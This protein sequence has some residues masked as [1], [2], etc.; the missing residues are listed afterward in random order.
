MKSKIHPSLIFRTPKFSYQ[1][2]LVSCWDELKKA[3]SISSAAFYETIKDV[4]AGELTNL[5][6]KIYFTIWKYFNRAKHRSTPYG[7]FA[8]FSFL[9]DGF[10]DE[11]DGITIHEEQL[12]HQFIDWPYRNEIHLNFEQLFADD[13]ILFSNTSYYLTHNSIRY[14]ACSDGIFELAEIDQHNF[15]MAIMA[16]CTVPIS[17]VN[18]VLKLDLDETTKAELYELLQDMHSLQLIFTDRDPNIIGEDY[19]KRLGLKAD[20][21]PKYLIAER[22]IISGG[23]DEKLL[24]PLPGLVEALSAI[25]NS[26]ERGALKSFIT[27]FKRKFDQQEVQLSIALDPE[28]GVGYDELE[29]A[30]EEDFVAQFTSAKKNDDGRKDLKSVLKTKLS[31]NVFQ[32]SDPIFLNNL[33]F[34]NNDKA[35]LLPNSFSLLMS[36]VDDLICIDQIGG[37]TANALTGRFTIADQAVEDYCKSISAIEQSAN[38]EV[39]FFDVAYLVETNVDNINRRKLVYDYQLS[40]LNFDTSSAPL[41]LR[42]IYISIRNDEVIL[43]SRQLNKR[44]IPRLA[45]AYN[46]TRSDLSVFR[47]LCDLQHHKIQTVLSFSLDSILPD[48]DFYPRFQHHNVVLSNAKWRVKKESFY[49]D[50]I[51][52]SIAACREYLHNI[53]LSRYFKTGSS[54]QTLCFDLLSDEDLN[55]FLQYMQKQTTLYLEEVMFPGNSIVRDEDGKPYSAQF[56]LSLYHENCIYKGLPGDNRLSESVQQVFL[57]GK[58]WL[59][60]EIYCHQQRSDE[61]LTVVIDA[62]LNDF[63]A[64]IKSWFFVR[65]NE[66]GNHLR[67]RI[68]LNNNE[69]GQVLLTSFSDYL[70]DYIES[71]LVSDLQVK[72]YKREL[73]RYGANLIA[74][75]EDHFALDSKVVLSFLQAQTDAFNKYKWCSKL[76]DSF[77]VAGIFGFE[78][79]IRMI[80]LVSDSFNEEHQIDAAGF[81][82]L[83]QHYQQYKNTPDFEFTSQDEIM[84]FQ[85]SFIELLK[86]TDGNKRVKLFTDLVHMHVNRLFNK[87]QRANEMVMYYFLLKDLQRK[88]AMN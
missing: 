5:P 55:A 86:L 23:L 56:I 66:N 45:S 18:L 12:V 3:I 37:V 1:A 44:L 11:S 48:L 27:R 77:R 64:K 46:Y 60:F 19:F 10:Q 13:A 76:I 17:I 43:R 57:P 50:K 38:P 54:D 33:S 29:Q 22:K 88:K 26:D 9:A 73:E 68:L 34:E 16:A 8:S 79:L 71:G 59:Y 21:L 32:N 30:G 7:T 28:M 2:D 72:T 85:Q 6:P 87:D 15:V 41:S 82:K 63:S 51:A 84:A 61:L 74:N 47:L 80:R 49:V 14:I 35:Q 58:E 69:D 67:F 65:Y 78:D 24:K 4:E 42:D 25:L 39:L 36:V 62:F 31:S 20:D 81:K 52:I 70:K 83:N 53:G 40:I 75:V